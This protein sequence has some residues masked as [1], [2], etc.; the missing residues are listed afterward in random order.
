M[1]LT[2]CMHCPVIAFESAEAKKTRN[3]SGM[4]CYDHQLSQSLAHPLNGLL[5]MK[6]DIP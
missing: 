5:P 6:Q 2:R 3:Q 1:K 4:L